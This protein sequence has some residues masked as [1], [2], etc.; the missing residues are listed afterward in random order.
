[1]KIFINT[2]LKILASLLSIAVFICIIVLILSFFGL[3][4]SNNQFMLLEGSETSSNKI[5]ILKLNGPIINSPSD[6][7]TFPGISL[8][9]LNVIKK[10]LVEVKKLEPKVLIISI[11]SPGGTVSASFEAYNLIKNFKIENDIKVF[12]HTSETLASGAYWLALAGD[13]IYAS[14]GSLIGSIGVKGPD[15]IYFDKPISI[16][17]GIFGNSIGTTGG[18]KVYSQNAG[19]SKDLLNPFRK[20]KPDELQKLQSMVDNIYNDFVNFVSKNRSLEINQVKNEIGAYLYNSS[21]AKSKFLIDEEISL[22][23]LI[24][25]IILQNNYKDYQV[26]E[27][28]NTK[29]FFIQNYFLENFYKNDIN[30]KINIKHLICNQ[31]SSNISS[32]NQNFFSNC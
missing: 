5:A 10:K 11:N 19:K 6:L 12:F 14:Y 1:M 22:S 24:K 28:T 21:N 25:K 8:I 20:P 4:N 7:N 2:F 27:S 16:S 17:S 30:D 18:I 3:K 26:Y 31:I 13:K 15:W 9:T 29:S 32:I 23:F